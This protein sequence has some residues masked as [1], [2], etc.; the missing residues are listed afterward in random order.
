MDRITVTA[1]LNAFDRGTPL[2]EDV[3]ASLEGTAIH[4][5]DGAPVG[6]L[7]DVSVSEPWPQTPTHTNQRVLSALNRATDDILRAVD[8][9]AT[10]LRDGL[11][12]LVNAAMSYLKGETHGVEAVVAANWD[13]DPTLEDVLGWIQ[14]G[15]EPRTGSR[16][17]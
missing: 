15:H 13:G 2:L 4:D 1:E 5:A 8:A 6:T 3:R 9:P 12:L 10:G 17:S 11:N 7:T 14:E 16:R